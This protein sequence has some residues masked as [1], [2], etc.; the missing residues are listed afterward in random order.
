MT[1]ITIQQLSEKH[2]VPINEASGRTS[3]LVDLGHV[4]ILGT[5][6]NPKTNRPNTLYRAVEICLPGETSLSLTLKKK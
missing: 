6:R 2:G 1:G 4:I 5:V 3:E